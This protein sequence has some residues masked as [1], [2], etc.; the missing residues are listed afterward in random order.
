MRCVLANI[1]RFGSLATHHGIHNV[2]SASI[3]HA[4]E[5]SAALQGGLRRIGAR[6]L[7]VD[8]DKANCYITALCLQLLKF[9][10]SLIPESV[11][12]NS[13]TDFQS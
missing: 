9:S 6:R 13:S 12:T 7:Q 3:R 8:D 1:H 11:T 5:R 2:Y 4:L 10:L